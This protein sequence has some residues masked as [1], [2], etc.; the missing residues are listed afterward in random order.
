MVFA[1]QAFLAFRNAARRDTVSS[2]IQTRIG[3]AGTWGPVDRRDI[4]TLAGDPAVVLTVRFNTRAEQES[5]M[6]DLDAAVGTGV[7]GPVTGVSFR[8]WHDCPHDQPN[9]SPCVVAG[10]KD[11]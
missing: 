10:R 5:F 7:N 9:V 2:N 6:A 8:T 1:V 3:Q 11:W 4:T